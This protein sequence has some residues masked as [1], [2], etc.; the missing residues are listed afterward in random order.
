MKWKFHNAFWLLLLL[1]SFL[2][3]DCKPD[4]EDSDFVTILLRIEHKVGNQALVRDQLNFSN[5][6]NQK[7]LL[8]SADYYISNVKLVSFQ[9]STD[10]PL[11]QE[12]ESY[13]LV[14]AFIKP[15]NTEIILK[16]VP[17]K[18]FD[19][20]VFSVGVDSVANSR[21]DQIGDL[22]PGNGGMAWDWTTGYK[23]FSLTGRWQDS[24]SQKPLV[25]HIGEN[26]N[27]KTFQFSF[28]DLLGTA[29][30]IEKS[31]AINLV[32]D[33]NEA[34]VSPENV[35]FKTTNTVHSQANGSK[36]IANNY[37]DGL[38]KMVGAQ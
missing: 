2:F 10:A 18:K 23:F 25:F 15:S 12:V 20:L 5:G 19:A 4:D 1:A 28:Y 29:Y 37:A 3:S 24:L 21:T 38:F 27:Y 26:V 35:N 14:N 33:L 7:Y 34:F 22:D 11:Y 36:I 31:G 32:C 17:K 6:L 8:S 9:K 13:H 16:N 30:D